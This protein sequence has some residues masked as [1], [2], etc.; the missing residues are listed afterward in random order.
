MNAPASPLEPD[1]AAEMRLPEG[2]SCGDCTHHR[3]CF[4]LGFSEVG[5]TSCDFHPSR[6]RPAA[7]FLD[8]TLYVNGVQ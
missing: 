7:K 3:R 6:Y 4:G 5:R 2:K 1:Y 8:L